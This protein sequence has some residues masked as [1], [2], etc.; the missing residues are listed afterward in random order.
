MRCIGL[1]NSFLD[2]RS[3]CFETGTKDRRV[4]LLARIL[5]GDRFNFILVF[6]KHSQELK[7]KLA[8]D[9]CIHQ[10]EEWR[11]INDSPR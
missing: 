7:R 3:Q 10:N 5:L 6:F 2:L 11:L 9:Y 1:V 4:T 8:N